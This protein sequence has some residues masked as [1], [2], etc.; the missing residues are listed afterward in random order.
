MV[1]V[2]QPPKFADGILARK[3]KRLFVGP[4][5]S[6][7]AQPQAKARSGRSAL[8][9]ADCPPPQSNPPSVNNILA[10]LP[11]EE[12]DRLKPHLQRVSLRRGQ[13]VRNVADRIDA[14]CFP[15]SG[16]IGLFAVMADGRTVVLAAT[17]QE[18]F[19]G[20][21]ALLAGEIAPLRALVL[22]EG[23]VLNL[24][25]NHLQ[26]MLSSAP[27]FAAALRRYCSSYLAQILRIGACHALH[28]VQQRVAFWLLMTRDRSGS[29]LLPFTHES[30]SELLGCRRPS[31]TEA[32]AQLENA[33]LIEGGRGQISISD[34]IG[35]AAQACECYPALR[36]PAVVA[37]S[38]L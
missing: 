24:S 17:G 37:R 10:C 9:G 30:L 14:L 12:L 5:P 21:T 13:I 29:D 27:Q 34:S 4:I 28:S 6:S 25:L 32:L 35:L 1:A 2:A 8:A 20:V 18:G 38:R 31:I 3:G 15:L 11:E 7:L 22:I 19:L 16:M 23:D 33:G 26:R 36:D